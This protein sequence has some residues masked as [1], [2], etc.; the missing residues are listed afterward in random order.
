MFCQDI[1]LCHISNDEQNEQFACLTLQSEEELER[2]TVDER[3]EPIER[4]VYLLR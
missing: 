2:H 3:L 1:V 4:A